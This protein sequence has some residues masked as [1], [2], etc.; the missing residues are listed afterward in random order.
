[1]SINFILYFFIY[2][3][4]GWIT[5]VIFCLIVD[6]EIVNRGF[7]KGPICPIY[8]AGAVFVLLLLEGFKGRIGV[9][10]ILGILIASIIEYLTSCVLE[11]IFQT[12]W[13]D[14]SNNRFNINGRICL[15]NSLLFGVLAVLLVEIIHPFLHKIVNIMPRKLIIIVTIIL[16]TILLI[17]LV[18]SVKVLLSINSNVYK[19]ENFI[20]EL[21]KYNLDLYSILQDDGRKNDNK[22][23][24][25]LKAKLK[26]KLN[27]KIN[28][29]SREK[30]LFK[31]FP[32]GTHKKYNESFKKLKKI[33]NAKK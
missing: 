16:L 14:Y 27:Q 11:N 19:L 30:S 26:E 8:G 6:K 2:G 20:Q 32:K 5:E 28:L 33:I 4:I 12:K 22:D 9:I 25:K 21:K 29:T 13:W 1:M 10:F 18:K 3:V 7:L 23:N 31:A 24:R 15:L 17:D